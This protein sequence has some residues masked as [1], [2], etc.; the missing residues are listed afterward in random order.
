[1]GSG[2][3]EFIA[4]IIGAL[5][6]AVEAVI[7]VRRWWSNKNDVVQIQAQRMLAAFEKHEIPRQQIV[8][9]LPAQFAIPMAAF[10]SDEKLKEVLT[11]SLLDWASETLCISRAWLDGVREHPH[12]SVRVYKHPQR[13]HAWLQERCIATGDRTM[14]LHVFMEGCMTDLQGVSGPFV[15]V[16]EECFGEL[17]QR[18]ISRYWVMSEGWHFEHQPCTIDLLCMMTIA[19]SLHITSCG[20]DVNRRLIKKFEG[21]HLLAPELIDKSRRCCRIIEWVPSAGDDATMSPYHQAVWR[22]AKERLVGCGL[23]DSLWFDK[24]VFSGK[25]G[26]RLHP[27]GPANLRG[28][29]LPGIPPSDS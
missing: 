28:V 20:H 4:G 23:E 16:L 22:E 10:S 24:A 27:H 18:G 14:L 6:Q 2:V 19:E 1:M 15:V 8:R 13:M 29:R 12:E 3:I 21:G 9:I 5:K 26:V 17:D 25:K 11:P 7:K